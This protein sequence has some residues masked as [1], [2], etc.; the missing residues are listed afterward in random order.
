MTR[1]ALSRVWP[2]PALLA[3]AVVPWIPGLPLFWI[4]LLNYAG[5]ASVL[6]I[7]LVVLTGIGGMTSFGQASFLGF[8]AYTTALL[9]IHGI[10]P[11][12]TLPAAIGV[13][14]LAALAI[15]AVTLRLSGHYLALGTMAWGVSLY[16]VAANLDFFGRNDGISDI[17]P[18]SVFGVKLIDGRLYFTLVWLVVVLACVATNNLL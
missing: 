15:G 2:L 7:G 17:P 4:T 16:Y 5:I 9:S 3:C 10:S 11:W 13:T 14:M 1:P 12:L 6:V 18:V 8:G